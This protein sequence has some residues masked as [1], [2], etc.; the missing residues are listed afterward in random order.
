[1]TSFVFIGLRILFDLVN[2]IDKANEPIQKDLEKYV[3]KVC[4]AEI[5]CIKDTANKVN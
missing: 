1:V 2:R 4:M 5:D 3:Y